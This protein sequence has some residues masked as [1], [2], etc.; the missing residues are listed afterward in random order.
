MVRRLG[1]ARLRFES[2]CKQS[3][4]IFKAA[5]R[6]HG[7][8]MT[9]PRALVADIVAGAYGPFDFDFVFARA[10]DREPRISRGTVYLALR[11][12]HAADLI[13]ESQ[14]RDP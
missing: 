1:A 13:K 5:C 9:G 7:L 3:P 11:R 12:F 8:R 10:R 14:E 4:D 6:R 2:V